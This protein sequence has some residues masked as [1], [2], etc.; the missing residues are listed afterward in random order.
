LKISNAE[1]E[2]RE[3]ERERE[4]ERKKVVIFY[5]SFYI[6]I[7]KEL[8]KCIHKLIKKESAVYNKFQYTTYAYKM[9]ENY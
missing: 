4:R 5:I 7:K 6:F 8:Y 2:C 1:K 9:C 3:K